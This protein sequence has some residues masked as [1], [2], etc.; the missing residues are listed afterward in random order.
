MYNQ[1]AGAPVHL[2]GG[3]LVEDMGSEF[4]SLVEENVSKFSLWDMGK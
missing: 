4:V 2:L 1:H 3:T